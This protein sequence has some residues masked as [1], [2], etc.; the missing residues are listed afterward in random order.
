[1]YGHRIDTTPET[2]DGTAVMARMIDGL[3]FR[4][5]WATDGLREED[6]DFRPGP[7]CMTTLELLRH[8]D[9]LA[10]M[11]HQT[12]FDA[13][14]RAPAEEGDGA[15]VRATTLARLGEARDRLDALSDEA[16]AGHRVLRREG[17][18][19]PVWNILNGPLADALTHV[20][21]LNSWRRL[22]GNPPA[23]ANVFAGIPPKGAADP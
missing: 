13:P 11:I 18:T 22:N 15:A 19:F 3:A 12:V 10:S 17:Q 8:V 4:Y 7:D 23:R 5:H 6:L 20:G 21:Q 14:A 9:L 16:L 1:M 2:L